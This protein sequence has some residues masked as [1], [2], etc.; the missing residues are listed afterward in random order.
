M[1]LSFLVGIS[2]L[3]NISWVVEPMGSLKQK[4]LQIGFKVT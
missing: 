2:Y 1:A 3:K 4:G